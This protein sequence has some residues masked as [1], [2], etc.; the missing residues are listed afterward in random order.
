MRLTTPARLIDLN[1][2]EALAYITARDDG[3]AIGAMTRQRAAERS[4]LV[5]EHVSLLVDA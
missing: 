1:R 5:A 4:P 3:L 2:V